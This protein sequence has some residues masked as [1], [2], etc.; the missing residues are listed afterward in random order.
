MDL[1]PT[2]FRRKSIRNYIS[3]PLNEKVLNEVKT[4]LQKLEPL[5]ENIEIETKILS[6]EEVNQRMM[7]KAPHYIA[8]FSQE[9]EDYKSNLGYMIQQ[10][11]LY[12]SKRGIGACWQGIPTINKKVREQTDLKFVILLAFGEANEQLH[13]SDV[14]E[15]KRKRFEEISNNTE[16]QDIIEAARLA[17][18]ATN[19]QPWYFTGDKHVIN[20]YM[21]KPGRIRKLITG[22]YPPIDMGIALYHLKVAGEHFN[23]KVNII[24]NDETMN[25]SPINTEY[26]ASLKL[27]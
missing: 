15:F 18:S 19:S 7:K 3:N 17:P 9:K 14:S 21:V 16:A 5:Y 1:Y 24:K 13:R 2:I 20:A 25:N 12:L 27:D 26:V 8:V 11:D 6:P 22:K 4:Q 10:M 23:H